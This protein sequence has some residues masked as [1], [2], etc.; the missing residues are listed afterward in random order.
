MFVAA[1]D[2]LRRDV[3]ALSSELADVGLIEEKLSAMSG[4]VALDG[5]RPVGYLTSWFPIT[6]FRN[7]DRT[8]A[9]APVWGHGVA[10][11]A[12]VTAV[13]LPLSRASSAAWA[14][15]RCSVDALA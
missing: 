12:D 9:Y 8:G 6:S 5:E 7:S 3:P 1:L 15:A 13:Y 2:G 11:D 10:A 4:T 14:A